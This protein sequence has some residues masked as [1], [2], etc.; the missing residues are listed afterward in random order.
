[1]RS[2]RALKGGCQLCKKVECP[3]CEKHVEIDTEEHYEGDEKYQCIECKKYFEVHAEPTISYSVRG[4]ADCLNGGEH[5]WV[6]QIG[7]PAIYYKGHYF[8]K[9]CSATRIVESETATKE[10]WEK[11]LNED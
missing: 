2:L 6:Q 3:Y 7:T 11:F 8:C 4:K 5:E 10:E 1:M 9:N